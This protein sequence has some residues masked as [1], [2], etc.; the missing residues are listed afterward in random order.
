MSQK[1]KKGKKGAG[2]A[3]ANN[4]VQL[5]PAEKLKVIQ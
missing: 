4:M 2:N 5:S 1:S 3:P